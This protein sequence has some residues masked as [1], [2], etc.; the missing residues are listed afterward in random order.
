MVFFSSVCWLCTAFH[1]LGL[2][3][4]LLLVIG[5]LCP[6]IVTSCHW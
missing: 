2:F 4:V 6:V 5:R 3:A 1:G